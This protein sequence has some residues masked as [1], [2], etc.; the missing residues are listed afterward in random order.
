MQKY[1]ESR[2]KFFSTGQKKGKEILNFPLDKFHFSKDSPQ[3]S[4]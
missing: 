2:V 1:T 3:F 4:G